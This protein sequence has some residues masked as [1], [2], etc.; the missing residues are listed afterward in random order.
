MASHH[1]ALWH[2]L[3]RH[4]AIAPGYVADLL[5]LP[6]LVS[7]QPT[8]VLKN[9][10]TIEDVPRVE[11]PDWVRQSV[12]VAP[13]SPGDFEIAWSGGPA[14]AIGLIEDQVVTESLE[15]EPVVEGGQAVASQQ[16]DLAKIAVV[17]RHLA[18]GR[19]GLGFVVR[20]G[21]ESGCA[22]LERRARRPQSGRGRDDRSRH[23]VRSRATRRDRRRDRGRGRPARSRRVPA[24]GRR[25]SLRRPARRRHR[26]EP[27]LQRGGARTRLDRRDA[28]PHARLSR[29]LGDPAPE[30][31]RPRPRR[32]RPLR[33]RAARGVRHGVRHP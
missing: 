29:A 3:A 9:G 13:L 33:D 27:R 8:T 32:R 15:R 31:H 4:G 1:P 18:T 11:I 19:V 22:R 6:D 14:R 17:E 2:R 16:H 7:F 5:V 12:R 21:S 10:R 26:A 30:D 28:V 25:A 20:I 23:G 24:T